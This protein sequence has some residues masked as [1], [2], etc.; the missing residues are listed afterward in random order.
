MIRLNLTVQSKV[1]TEPSRSVM[2]LKSERRKNKTRT[3]CYRSDDVERKKF[4]PA[5]QRQP[6]E[7]L[8]RMK[9]TMLNDFDFA[10]L[11]S[12]TKLFPPLSFRPR[13]AK[14]VLLESTRQARGKHRVY[15]GVIVSR[16]S[17]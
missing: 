2:R 3:V 4:W 16:G 9:D 1:E 8:R 7:L 15:V 5:A 17:E 12:L 11:S 6:G 14:S 13:V 10:Y